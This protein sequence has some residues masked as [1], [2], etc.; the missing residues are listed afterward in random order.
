M[1]KQP[2]TLKYDY[3]EH[4]KNGIHIYRKIRNGEYYTKKPYKKWEVD[5]KKNREY[6]EDL[7]NLRTQFKIDLFIYFGIVENPKAEVFWDLIWSLGHA[8]G[9]LTIMSWAERLIKLIN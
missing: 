3:K 2:G 4:P 9:F 1:A 8:N 6:H 5:A 7:R